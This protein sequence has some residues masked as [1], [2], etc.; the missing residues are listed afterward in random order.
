MVD[1]LAACAVPDEQL[2]FNANPTGVAECLVNF[3]RRIVS[4]GLGHVD[5]PNAISKSL[6]RQIHPKYMPLEIA[7]EP[8]DKGGLFVKN[9]YAQGGFIRR[10]PIQESHVVDLEL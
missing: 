1:D 3:D 2:L 5:D 4:W 10:D 7:L 6:V 8:D 9:G